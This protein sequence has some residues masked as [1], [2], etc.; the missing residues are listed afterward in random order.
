MTAV[1]VEMTESAR[2]QF[3]R[4]AC[5]VGHNLHTTDLFSDEALADLLDRFPRQHLYAL[6]MG[7]DPTRP[8]ENRLALH[9]GVSGKELLRAVRHGRLWLNITRV[10]RVDAQYR[11]LIDALYEQLAATVSDFR[12]ISSQGTL[13]V[14][15]PRALVYYHADGPASALW[16]IRGRKQ[17]WVYPALDERFA[18]REFIEDIFAGVRHEYLPYRH[19]FDT[20]AQCYE[21]EPGQCVSWPQNAPHRVTNLDSLNVSLSTEYFTR[22]S[23]QRQRVYIANRFFRT[24][25]GVRNPSAHESGLIAAGKVFVQRVANKFGLDPVQYRSHSAAL[26]VDAD[27]PHGVAPLA[28]DDSKTPATSDAALN[29]GAHRKMTPPD[30]AIAK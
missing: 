2:Q 12:P 6:S 20:D 5:L 22:A 3:G 13:L 30:L 4:E 18:K 26:R 23:R 27:A 11:V 21:L 16:H 15:S 29:E 10:D 1:H 9:D 14:S 25:L 8:D 7:D 24:R 28:A 17:V 19:D